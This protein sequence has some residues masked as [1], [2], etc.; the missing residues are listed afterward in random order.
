[1]DTDAGVRG[2]NIML[3][4]HVIMLCFDARIIS[5]LCSTKQVIMLHK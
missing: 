1:M 5:P 3:Q 2:A 4:S